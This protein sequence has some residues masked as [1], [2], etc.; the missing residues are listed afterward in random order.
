MQQRVYYD[1]SY[2]PVT[3]WNSIRLLLIMTAIHRW[4]TKQLD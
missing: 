1:H 3:S 2:A 4:Y